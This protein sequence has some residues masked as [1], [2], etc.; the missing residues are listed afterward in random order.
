M[1]LSLN[2]LSQYYVLVH[3]A[4]NKNKVEDSVAQEMFTQ[5]EI[6]ILKY[7]INRLNNCDS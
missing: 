1:S 4:G 6:F 5:V 3:D 7:N 2:S